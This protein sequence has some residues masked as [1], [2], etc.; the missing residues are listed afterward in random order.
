MPSVR[1]Y[2]GWVC[3]L[4][5]LACGAQG[6]FGPGRAAVGVG[7][8]SCRVGSAHRTELPEG[9]FTVATE[10]LGRWRRVDQTSLLPPIVQL[11]YFF[12]G[13]FFFFFLISWTLKHA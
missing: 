12:L 11:L 2:L 4:E 7:D 3:F 13:F 5:A 8:W 10:V 6:W 9:F 1:L